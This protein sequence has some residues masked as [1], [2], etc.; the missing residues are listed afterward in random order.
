MKMPTCSAE[1]DISCPLRKARVCGTIGGDYDERGSFLEEKEMG[2]DSQHWLYPPVDA[3]C[4]TDCV[5]QPGAD[6][7]MGR[8]FHAGQ[9][10]AAAVPAG[11]GRLCVC[12]G[13]RAVHLPADGGVQ[14]QP[15]YGD[16]F[17]LRGHLLCERHARLIRWSADADLPDEPALDSR[18]CGNIGADGAVFLQSAD[19]GGDDAAAV[20]EQ[21]RVCG[22]AAEQCHPADYLR[23]C[24]K[25]LLCAVDSAGDVPPL[26]GGENCAVG[27]PL[28]DEN[29]HL[30]EAGAMAGIRRNDD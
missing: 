17:L 10:V 24:S 26:V 13:R 28:P 22:G 25:F 6:E 5:Q 9:A 30:Q 20:A 8:A 12:R 1:N 19:I 18:G 7:R 14:S 2:Q 4:G 23:L 3:D 16:A 21:P 15:E 27:N 29:P 11:D